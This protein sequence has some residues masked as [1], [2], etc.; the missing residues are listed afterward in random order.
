MSENDCEPLMT[1]NDDAVPRVEEP[2]CEQQNS[3][4][5]KSTSGNVDE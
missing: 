1:D 4:I 5:E 3:T 2:N